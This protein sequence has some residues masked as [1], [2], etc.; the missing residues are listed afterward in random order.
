MEEEF[1]KPDNQPKIEL[2]MVTSLE[3]AAS[4]LHE[5]YLGLIW[6]GFNEKQALFILGTAVSGGM[7][8]PFRHLSDENELEDEDIDLDDLDDGEVF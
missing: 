8:S 4:E 3:V 1:S 5:M 6:A 2:P 7:L